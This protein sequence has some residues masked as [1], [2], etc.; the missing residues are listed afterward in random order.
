MGKMPKLNVFVKPKSNKGKS[1][2]SKDIKTKNS[3]KNIKK[4][5]FELHKNETKKHSK[6]DE[7]ESK[8]HSETKTGDFAQ[9][10]VDQSIPEQLPKESKKF[11]EVS[12]NEVLYLTPDGR[13]YINNPYGSL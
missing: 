13:M 7:D 6:V 3:V 10:Q 9:N 8:D 2:N 4:S 1:I 11:V 12:S 5:L